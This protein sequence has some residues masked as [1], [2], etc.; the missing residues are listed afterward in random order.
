MGIAILGSVMTSRFKSELTDNVS[1]EVKEVLTPA[2]LTA[3]ADNPRAL[4]GSEA[5]AKLEVDYF[6]NLGSQG[7]DLFH[8]LMDTM[9]HALSTTLTDLFLIALALAILAMLVVLFMKKL[10][11]RER[12]VPD[13]DK[14]PEPS[15]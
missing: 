15:G 1:P 14:P 5:Q 6:S 7:T 4:M 13:V 11:H 9:K 8:Q 3:L 10:P 2:G 12:A